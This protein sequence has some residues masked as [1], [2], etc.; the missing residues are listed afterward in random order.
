MSKNESSQPSRTQEGGAG[1]KTVRADDA[2][3]AFESLSGGDPEVTLAQVREKYRSVAQWSH[4]AK[5][6]YPTFDPIWTT[7]P[8]QIARCAVLG[9]HPETGED[10]AD[11]KQFIEKYENR[12]NPSRT[13]IVTTYYEGLLRNPAIQRELA[14]DTSLRKAQM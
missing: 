3:A 10:L 8:L 7:D 4:T 14:R 9:I 12:K 13:I 5:A 6:K 2:D 1:K 11:P